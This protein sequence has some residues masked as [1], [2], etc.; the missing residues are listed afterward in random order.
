MSS[1]PSLAPPTTDG[2]RLTWLRLLRSH[3]VGPST[4]YR[5]MAEHAGDADAA[6]AALPQIAAAAG[7]ARYAPCP[8]DVVE[9]ELAAG[10]RAGAT[11]LFIGHPAYPPALSE[12]PDA[13]PMLW[14]RGEVALTSRATVALVGARNASSIGRR[15]ARVLAAG[16][17]EAGLVIASGLA[18]GIDA[19]VHTAALP[20]GT[21]AVV[22]G[23]VDVIYPRENTD[24]T[25]QIAERGL[26]LSE[27]PPGMRPQARHFPRRNRIISGISRAVVVVE[28]AAKS[29]SLITA[30]DALDQGRD[31]LAVPGHPFDARASGCNLLIRD[32]APLVRSAGDVLEALGT[33]EQPRAATGGQTPARQIRRP[34]APQPPLFLSPPPAATPSKH[35][36]TEAVR[37]RILSLLGPTPLAEDQLLRDLSLPGPAVA[38]HLLSLEM[39][40]AVVRQPGGLLTRAV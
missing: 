7:V 25:H 33:I 28:A 6:L 40:G 10:R 4:F 13:P 21:V 17:G 22:A 37:A 19:E 16:L 15:M 24:L 23:G 5:L 36:R 38:E 18:R 31:V 26:I 12:L 39:D 14:A 32:G 8:I 35:G 34:S 27:M 11:P 3:R 29:G 20:T 9:R 1:P 2:A 30:R